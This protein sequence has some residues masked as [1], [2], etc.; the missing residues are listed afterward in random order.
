MD[1]AS[2]QSLHDLTRAALGKEVFFNPDAVMHAAVAFVE[3]GSTQFVDPVQLTNLDSFLDFVA[4]DAHRL[5]APTQRD[6]AAEFLRRL[7]GGGLQSPIPDLAVA[8]RPPPLPSTS[9]SSIALPIPQG[10]QPAFDLLIR[11][12][13]DSLLQLYNQAVAQHTGE[14]QQL[15]AIEKVLWLRPLEKRDY[16]AA[17]EFLE[18]LQSGPITHTAAQR[19]QGRFLIEL[20]APGNDPH[21]MVERLKS[22][23]LAQRIG[24]YA[25]A[26]PVVIE[27][28]PEGSIRARSLPDLLLQLSTLMQQAAEDGDSHLLG[29]LA[30]AAKKVAGAIRI[31]Q[32]TGIGLAAPPP[33]PLPRI[34]Q[35]VPPFR[36]DEGAWK[37]FDEFA[38]SPGMNALLMPLGVVEHVMA[39]LIMRDISWKE[40]WD[41]GV[42]ALGGSAVVGGGLLATVFTWHQISKVLGDQKLKMILDGINSRVSPRV[43]GY[44]LPILFISAFSFMALR[45]SQDLPLDEVWD[46]RR[47]MFEELLEGL[48]MS[49]VVTG[50]SLFTLHRLMKW[51]EEPISKQGARGI[52]IVAMGAGMLAQDLWTSWRRRQKSREFKE[53]TYKAVAE[54]L[55]FLPT[56][57][58]HMRAP[59]LENI[60]RKFSILIGLN[61][62]EF[63]SVEEAIEYSARRQQVLENYE[64]VGMS[65]KLA[66]ELADM[67]ETK[68]PL[69]KE[70]QDIVNYL[71]S[72][73]AGNKERAATLPVSILSVQK[74]RILE[75]WSSNLADVAHFLVQ[76]IPI[77]IGKNSDGS[78]PSAQFTDWNIAHTMA[79][80]RQYVALREKLQILNGPLPYVENEKERN[81]IPASW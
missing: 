47:N 54:L 81:G 42:G 4:T 52:W 27:V 25:G 9:P 50:G 59:I 3:Q 30:L 1:T 32:L 51:R 53:Q 73:I 34:F 38:T 62:T 71:L 2:L 63:S 23:G 40:S 31:S 44:L 35:P 36:H 5:F 57:P 46:Y 21:Q 20:L 75:L 49:Y 61:I 80:F 60:D 13:H 37:Y 10:T 55:D 29:K 67:M 45:A 17:V 28:F 22:S 8:I 72:K 39:S 15:R 79:L 43:R 69:T 11:A 64:G 74:R 19:E 16:R 18:L 7:R 56:V 65:P 68:E 78:I 70:A 58:E 24:A 76:P 77:M 12:P 26:T 66:K 6:Q 41:E 48:G 33:K 14:P